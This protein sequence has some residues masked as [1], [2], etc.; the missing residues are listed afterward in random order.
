M[1]NIWDIV[2]PEDSSLTIKRNKDELFEQLLTF[3]SQQ[4]RGQDRK[5]ADG[6]IPLRL[7]LSF[8]PLASKIGRGKQLHENGLLNVRSMLLSHGVNLAL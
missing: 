8:L 2:D 1:V 4:D 7:W 5:A 3:F 6:K